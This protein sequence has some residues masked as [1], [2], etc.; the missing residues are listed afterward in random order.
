LSVQ[1]VARVSEGTDEESWNMQC[2]ARVSAGKDERPL[3]VQC[4]AARGPL[5]RMRGP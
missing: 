3:S 4:V 5:G 1:C 2:V